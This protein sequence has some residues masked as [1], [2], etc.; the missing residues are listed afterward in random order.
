MWRCCLS[1]ERKSDV[2]HRVAKNK[3]Y[4]ITHPDKL[5]VGV[6]MIQINAFFCKGIF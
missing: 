6:C 4:L 3:E 5:G 1:P 2:G